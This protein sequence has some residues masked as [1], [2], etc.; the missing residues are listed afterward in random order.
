MESLV[1]IFLE[2]GRHHQIRV[3]FANAHHPLVGDQK[4]GKSAPGIQI[5]LW[6]FEIEFKHPTRDEIMKFRCFPEKVGVWRNFSHL[7]K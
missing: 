3:Q 6:A 7:D 2:T 4:Y 5:A 1:K